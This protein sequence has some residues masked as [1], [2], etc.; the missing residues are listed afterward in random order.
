MTEFE[1][2]SLERFACNTEIKS[3]DINYDKFLEN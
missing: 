2:I 3:S 1:H